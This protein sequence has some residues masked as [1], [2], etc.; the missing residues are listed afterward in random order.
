MFALLQPACY[1]EVIYA[2]RLL[3]LAEGIRYG[4]GPVSLDERFPEIVLNCYRLQARC[5]KPA[6]LPRILPWCIVSA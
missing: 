4:H 6:G 2:A 1:G 3:A 5:F